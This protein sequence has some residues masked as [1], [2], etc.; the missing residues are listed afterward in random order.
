MGGCASSSFDL[1]EVDIFLSQIGA[2]GEEFVGGFS[3]AESYY[4]RVFDD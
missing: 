3:G 4:G 2:I 1:D